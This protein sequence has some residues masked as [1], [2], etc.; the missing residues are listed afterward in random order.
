MRTSPG[1]QS[2]ASL[3]ADVDIGPLDARKRS[4]IL[5]V[6]ESFSAFESLQGGGSAA[7]A[8]EVEASIFTGA[9]VKFLKP[10]QTTHQGR[11]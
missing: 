7:L 1:S 6:N 2:M 3:I 9:I 10:G 4:N 11:Q 8:L 5:L